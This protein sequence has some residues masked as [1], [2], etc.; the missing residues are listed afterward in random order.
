[1]EGYDVQTEHRES[2]ARIDVYGNRNDE[3]V[4]VEV[5]DLPNERAEYLDDEYTRFVHI[6]YTEFATSEN[7]PN[8][9][10]TNISIDPDS[11]DRFSEVV[12]NQSRS[13]VIRDFVRVYNQLNG[14]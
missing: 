12:E 13:Q 10:R 11:W 3:T 6:P 1:M 7:T 9:K 5:G 14:E 4:A 8:K 2:G